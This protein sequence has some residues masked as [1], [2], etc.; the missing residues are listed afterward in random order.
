MN[1]QINMDELNS[2]LADKPINWREVLDRY[3]S[4]K[5][6]IF[7][8]VIV[9]LILGM[10]FYRLQMDRYQLKST[11]LISN[12]NSSQ[13]SQMSVLKQ[14]DA[15]GLSSGSGTNIYNEN[16]VIH[17][18]SLIRK[19]VDELGLS[20]R[21]SKRSYFKPSDIYNKTP[22]ILQ[23]KEEDLL[24]LEESL[25][26]H[27]KYDEKDN[28]YNISGEYKYDS[29]E[30]TIR[31]LPTTIN[32]PGGKIDIALTNTGIKPEDEIEVRISNPV[33]VV[34]SYQENGF[35]TEVDEDGDIIYLTLN[36]N[37]VQKGKDILSKLIDL[38]NQDAIDQINKS[39]NFTALF[40]DGRLKILTSELK[41]VEK[42]IQS[43]K[44]SNKLTD[45]ETD[46]E[47][48]LQRNSL[49]DQRENDTQ[50]QLQL[51]KYIEEFIGEDQNKYA[52][53]PNLGI[54][55]VGLMGVITEYNKL[56]ATR[57]RVS[58]G[59]SESN[60]TLRQLEQQV[61]ST[62]AAIRKSINNT[63]RGLQISGKELT[64]Q[65]NFLASQLRKI[66]QQEREFLEIKRQQQIKEALYLFLLQKREEASLSMA[67]TVPKGRLLDPADSADKTSP[68]L[69]M[70]LA[71]SLMLGFL[72]P[73]II[74]YLKFLFNS[75][76]SSRKEVESL[77]R[78][79]IIA[80]LAH[81]KDNDVIIDHGTNASANAELLRLLRSKLQFLMNRPKDRIILVTSTES[82]EGKTFVSINLAVSI[83][84]SGKKVL[85]MGMDLRKPMLAR[86]FGIVEQEGISSYLSGLRSDYKK[87]I[88]P[89]KEFTNLN[90]LPGGII[91][92]NPNEL[93]MSDKFDEL[94]AE[95]R[96]IYDYIIIDSAPVGAVSDTFLINRVSNL[97]L[98]ITRANYSDK[99]NL[100]YLNRIGHENSL[101]QLYLIINDVDIEN[102]RY[103]NKYG[104][105]Y[106]YGYGKKR[107]VKHQV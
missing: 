63:K 29:F 42:N 1:K 37:N 78:V 96:E 41:D 14:L 90:I 25:I 94:I 67:V 68:K 9:A 33:S 74:L 51:I 28:E 93:I 20:Y 34:K 82:G 75:N 19:V 46:A 98:Y 35:V 10:I 88:H 70:I 86:H 15:F 58:S 18:R 99:R 12:E 84:L 16:K 66:P 8:G 38:Y 76:F 65:N 13:M 30:N 17:S 45:I 59:S 56:L 97:T 104:Y 4:Y 81:Q 89:T 77:T 92:P 85:L 36:E 100:E 32:T 43:Y 72:I 57:E 73:V 49:Y 101:K 39:A 44:Q 47:L 103:G 62:R 64:A 48:F 87:L 53:I 24:R 80:E 26:I 31:S 69:A 22:Y 50:I 95:L 55:D 105:G 106:G 21:Y 60:P 2:L 61:Q 71:L 3:L 79:P 91:P 5:K 23:M 83:S 7:A 40:I 6:W 11:L 102:N 54:T 107:A 52:L 27:V